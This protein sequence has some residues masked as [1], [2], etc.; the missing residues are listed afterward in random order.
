M[1]KK[2][3]QA[4]EFISSKLH[5]K[6]IHQKKKKKLKH[7]ITNYTKKLLPGKISQPKKKNK[8]KKWIRR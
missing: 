8:L 6:K 5:N 7:K 4:K 3:M 1:M 2:G